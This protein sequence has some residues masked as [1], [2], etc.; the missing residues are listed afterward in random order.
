[1]KNQCDR[2]NLPTKLK[3]RVRWPSDSEEPFLSPLPSLDLVPHYPPP[4]VTGQDRGKMRSPGESD[5][6]GG[7]EGEGDDGK[8][9]RAEARGDEG[10]ERPRN[11]PD[12][13]R[14]FLLTV[15]PLQS[16]SH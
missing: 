11:H 8:R 4:F 3:K 16:A 13:R 10:E 6:G 5:M 14:G 2:V 15:S 9:S 1:M 7:R 12:Q